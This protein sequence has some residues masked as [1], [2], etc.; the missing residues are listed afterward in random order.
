[1]SDDEPIVNTGGCPRGKKKRSRDNLFWTQCFKSIEELGEPIA[2]MKV[3]RKHFTD[4]DLTDSKK[5]DYAKKQLKRM[6]KK[7]AAI[8]GNTALGLRVRKMT[9]GRAPTTAKANCELLIYN[10]VLKVALMDGG[11]GDAH[12]AALMCTIMADVGGYQVTCALADEYLA[13]CDQRISNFL[14]FKFKMSREQKGMAQGP[15]WECTKLQTALA[16][17]AT[18]TYQ[19][20]ILPHR[21]ITGRTA[22]HPHPSLG[23]LRREWS[24]SRHCT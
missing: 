6:W 21:A 22:P 16:L 12:I 2:W 9:P 10:E 17:H 14:K 4:I 5:R 8:I 15:Q 20:H 18:E 7:R 24:R 19:A 1:M 13:T 11:I 23:R 3:V